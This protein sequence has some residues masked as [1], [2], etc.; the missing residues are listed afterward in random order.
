MR[1]VNVYRERNGARNSV[2]DGRLTTSLW[3]RLRG[4]LG[5]TLLAE[6]EAI[7]IAPCNSIHTFGMAYDIDVAFLDKDGQVIKCVE[8]I[9]P[10]RVAAAFSGCTVLET[11][12]G[13][14]RQADVRTGDRIF[15]C[16]CMAPPNC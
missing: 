9:R 4:L 14:L 11:V 5:S 7:V 10:R 6:R 16:Q 1:K 8:N 15:W 13:G 3:E 2:F 12:A